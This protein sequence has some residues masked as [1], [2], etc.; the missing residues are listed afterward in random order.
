MEIAPL[1]RI[2][3]AA[4]LT[5]NVIA[6]AGVDPITRA[7]TAILVIAL[8]Y[9]L[10]KTPQIPRLHRWAFFF[11]F[12][13]A[14]LQLLPMP[15]SVRQ[16]LMPGC[17]EFMSP[18]WAPLTL[19]PWA[20]VQVITSS[21]IVLGIALTSARMASTRSG[22]PVLLGI[23]AAIGGLIAILGL[24][25]E[26]GG[27]DTVLLMRENTGGGGP[28]GPFVNRNHFAQAIELTMPALFVLLAASARHLSRNRQSKERPIVFGLAGAI[29]IA[30]CIAAV[31]R[32]ASR[33]GALF[34]A[35]AAIVSIP[36]WLRYKGGRHW[37]WLLIFLI[38]FAAAGTFAWTNLPVLHERMLELVA[39]EGADG[40]TRLDLWR[41]TIDLSKRAPIFGIGLGAYRHAICLDKPATGVSIL[42][43]SHNDWL[44]FSAS[45]GLIGVIIVLLMLI[46]LAG[47]LNLRAVRRLR[48][49][50]R[51]P[52]AGLVIVLIATA[53]HEAIGFG[54]QIPLNRYLL[55]VWIGMF[56]G[57]M[58]KQKRPQPTHKSPKEN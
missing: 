39:I 13:L 30:V 9:D 49:E 57:I 25:S 19:A 40:N 23:I 14:T 38:I 26:G 32:S 20:T 50:Y 22:L 12:V 31:L 33:G 34:L 51:Y 18:G 47:P 37:P 5:L 53:L 45:G 42:D 35:V 43:H 28:Y 1:H 10:R 3:L 17:S 2:L 48:F 41:G 4:I 54:L 21:V 11:F 46:G 6:F 8:A 7:V 44:E 29:G 56:W 58:S 16:F 55:A 52:L 15:F 36:W 27:G 24:A